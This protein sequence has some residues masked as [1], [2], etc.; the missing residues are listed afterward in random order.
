MAR[1]K[2]IK[3][4]FKI[5]VSDFHLGKGRY[6][7]DG[8]QNILED[9][10]YDREFSEF[11]DYYRVGKFADAEVELIL[12]G[13]ILNLLQIDTWGPTRRRPSPRSST[14]CRQPHRVNSSRSCSTQA[15]RHSIRRSAG[16]ARR[17]SR[18]WI[19][20]RRPMRIARS[21]PNGS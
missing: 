8:T 18:R 5:V 16:S 20:L 17:F 12:N 4:K 10:I 21:R 9:F 11:I 13:D 1:H 2:K 3:P 7:E 15:P 14:P 19:G 6:F